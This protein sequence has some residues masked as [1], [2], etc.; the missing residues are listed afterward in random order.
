MLSSASISSHKKVHCQ[1]SHHVCEVCN[2]GTGEVCPR[3]ARGRRRFKVLSQ[4]QEN[5]RLEKEQK[6]GMQR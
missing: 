1:D 4:R 2:H 3:A 6:Q 5:V